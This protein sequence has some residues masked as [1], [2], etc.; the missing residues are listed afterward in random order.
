MPEFTII[1]ILGLK[2]DVPADDMSLFKF[3]GQ[4]VALTHDTA[5]QNVDYRRTPNVATKGEGYSA[6]SNS[7]VGSPTRCLGLFELDDG[8]NQDNIIFQDG[9]VY[10]YDSNPDPI[11]IKNA[12]IDYSTLSGDVEAGDC[13]GV[14]S[15]IGFIGSNG[16]PVRAVVVFKGDRGGTEVDVHG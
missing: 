13:P 5:G 11:Q 14:A 7:A 16:H 8:T 3:I 9:K 1:P 12:Y 6:W 4:R 15:I 10:Y 2:T